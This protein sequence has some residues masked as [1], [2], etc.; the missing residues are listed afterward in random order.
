MFSKK[1]SM[2]ISINT[3]VLLVLALVLVGFVIGSFTGMFNKGRE[4]LLQSIEK[5]DAGP[6]A[7]SFDLIAGGDAF[8]FKRNVDQIILVSFYN[9]GHPECE[10]FAELIMHCPLGVEGVYAE[11]GYE[12]ID[13]P[14]PIGT[15]KTIGGVMKMG[16]NVPR[17]DIICTLK[18]RCGSQAIIVAEQHSVFKVS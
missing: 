16:K 7:T 3:I 1:A 11:E 13:L 17:K 5:L 4:S 15:E 18:V 9:N 14:V 6:K 2:Q 12:N 8:K 10:E